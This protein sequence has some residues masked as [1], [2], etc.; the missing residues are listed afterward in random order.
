MSRREQDKRIAG[1]E[2]LRQGKSVRTK[3]PRKGLYIQSL[4]FWLIKKAKKK[5][6]KGGTPQPSRAAI[7]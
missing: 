3:T 4:R 6:G 5:E 1:G 2:D 7:L